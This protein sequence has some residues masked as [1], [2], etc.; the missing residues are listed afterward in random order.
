MATRHPY[1]G[2]FIVLEGID[3]SGTT[4]QAE[5]LL[6]RL[7]EQFTNVISTAQP[8]EGNP[9]GRLLRAY[10]GGTH[11]LPEFPSHIGSSIMTLLFSADRL[12]HLAEEIIPTLQIGGIVICDRYLL[13][14]YAY[15]TRKLDRYD[16][17]KAVSA[18]AIKPDMD[19]LLD[20]DPAVA[21]ARA[22]DRDRPPEFYETLEKQSAVE[23]N[24]RRLGNQASLTDL[25]VVN[26]SN[27]INEVA[28]DVYEIA[29]SVVRRKLNIVEK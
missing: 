27:P 14:T 9:I 2:V 5:I 20:I 7:K 1:P 25:R 16:W 21:L 6:N 13:S 8:D 11:K 22:E 15:Q 23:E 19:I 3:G 10:L 17:I 24:Y 26:A 18:Y 29:S 12:A 4:T 28:D